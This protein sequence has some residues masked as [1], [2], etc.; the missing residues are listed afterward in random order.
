MYLADWSLKKEIPLF[1]L[2]RLR[3]RPYRR[4]P[5][6]NSRQG[7]LQ[8]LING[9]SR[10]LMIVGG[11][12]FLA[13]DNFLRRSQHTDFFTSEAYGIFGGLFL[14]M[15][16]A[17]IGLLGK[18]SDRVAKNVVRDAQVETKAMD[19]RIRSRVNAKRKFASSGLSELFDRLQEVL[20]KSDPL[21]LGDSSSAK[22]EYGSPVSTILP[23][24]TNCSG[25]EEARFVI[26]NE[27]NRHY[28]NYDID[29]AQLD[30]IAEQC[31]N[32]WTRSQPTKQ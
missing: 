23:R 11:I 16:G 12:V 30:V 14:I 13:G 15:L 21:Q 8:K 31:W 17:G 22:D 20:Y 18:S 25:M 4:E 7:A 29:S 3:Y 5:M 1:S 9:F 28:P 27:F 24:L 32:E 2:D 6:D 10:V 19:L 26:E